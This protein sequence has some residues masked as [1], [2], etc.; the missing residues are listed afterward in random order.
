MREHLSDLNQLT[1]RKKDALMVELWE[2]IQK[3]KISGSTRS[4]LSRRCRDTFASLKKTCRKHGIAF[5]EYLKRP[6]LREKRHLA[7]A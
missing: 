2:E 3:R 1:D 5:C 4:D 7:V 6:D